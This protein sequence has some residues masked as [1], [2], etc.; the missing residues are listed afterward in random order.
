VQSILRSTYIIP[1]Q[2]FVY[3][4]REL[5]ILFKMALVSKIIEPVEIFPI[6]LNNFL[7]NF[8]NL[9]L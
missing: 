7:V 5:S 1:L 8:V 6:Q 3:C 4:K 9:G 2:G